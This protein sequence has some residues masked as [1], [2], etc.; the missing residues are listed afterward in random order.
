MFAQRCK[1][2]IPFLQSE[3]DAIYQL[4]QI[5]NGLSRSARFRLYSRVLLMS[6]SQLCGRIQRRLPRL[7]RSPLYDLCKLGHF[8]DKVVD[9]LLVSYAFSPRCLFRLD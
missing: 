1:L 9:P 3:R 8:L 5:T 2:A 6:C 4:P 7:S